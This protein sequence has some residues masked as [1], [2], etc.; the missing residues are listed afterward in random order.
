MARIFPS[1]RSLV[2][3][4]HVFLSPPHL[5]HSCSLVCSNL[6]LSLVT[7]AVLVSSLAIISLAIT[8]PVCKP[9]SKNEDLNRGQNGTLKS[10][11]YVAYQLRLAPVH[12][13]PCA[14]QFRPRRPSSVLAQARRL[15][16]WC[17]HLSSYAVL[18]SSLMF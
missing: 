16:A 12:V 9:R 5:L 18:P 4:A 7:T 8:I 6:A 11:E 15:I 14:P 13:S 10:G 1:L 3:G 2:D 17:D